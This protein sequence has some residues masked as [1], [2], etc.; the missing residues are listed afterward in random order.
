MTTIYDIL[1]S[2]ENKLIRANY[3]LNPFDIN[4]KS[5]EFEAVSYL[6]FILG[7]L[8][9]RTKY[10][11]VLRLRVAE[12]KKL[13]DFNDNYLNKL[14]FDLVLNMKNIRDINL[15]LDILLNDEKSII[16]DLANDF[17][18]KLNCDYVISDN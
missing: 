5:S 15:H 1:K 11:I 10:E 16:L 7:E 12:E 4:N 9:K 17:V 2:Q 6:D 8:P 14:S 3:L 18:K 13:I